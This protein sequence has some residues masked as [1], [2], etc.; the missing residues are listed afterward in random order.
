M[1]RLRSGTLASMMFLSD[2][3]MFI[4][5]KL[6]LHPTRAARLKP[7]LPTQKKYVIIFPFLKK[8]S[9]PYAIVW[10]AL[11]FYYNLNLV[12]IFLL[13]QTLGYVVCR[14]LS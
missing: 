12:F 11:L 14:P 10:Q 2:A 1:S 5:E 3:D 8:Q 4:W 6:E 7:K 13:S 9:L